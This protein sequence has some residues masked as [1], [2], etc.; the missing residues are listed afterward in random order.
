MNRFEQHFNK[1]QAH[2]RTHFNNTSNL[3]NRDIS[4]SIC[5]PIEP[6]TD[7][8]DRFWDY[9][10]Y[11]SP[12][13][14]FSRHT[15]IYFEDLLDQ[16]NNNSIQNP[17]EFSII[18]LIFSCRYSHIP[19]D[20]QLLRQNLINSLINSNYFQEELVIDY[21]FEAPTTVSP[22]QSTPDTLSETSDTDI[23]PPHLEFPFNQETPITPET[24]VTTTMDG[25]NQ[26]DL[27][28]LTQAINALLAPLQAQTQATNRNTNNLGQRETRHIEIQPFFG[29][30]QDPLTWVEDFERMA[31]ANG[32]GDNRKLQVIPAYLRGEASVWYRTAALT[33]AFGHWDDNA[34]ADSF[35]QR[36]L[37]KYR[38]SV[39][40][41]IWANELI[42]C[43]QGPTE[44]VDS[45]STRMYELY[46]RLEADGNDYP[47]AD[48]IR[49]FMG[50]LRFELQTAVR[51]FRDQD[52]DDVVNRAKS[53][54][55]GTQGTSMFA[56]TYADPIPT[57]L[58]TNTNTLMVNTL[59]TI[60]KQIEN[61]ERKIT[62]SQRNGN[63]NGNNTNNMNRNWRQNNNNNGNNNRP[64]NQNWRNNNNNQVQ[65]NNQF[66]IN[67]S[68]FNNNSNPIV[69]YNCQQP[70]H[71]SREC[72]QPKQYRNFNQQNQNFN[73][74]AFNQQNQNF[75]SN[76]PNQQT[77]NQQMH[78]SFNT[79]PP[80]RVTF[81]DTPQI[82]LS[83]QPPPK[84]PN[85]E[86]LS[87]QVAALASLME[88]LNY[89]QHQ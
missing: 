6:P 59:Q 4:C 23:L 37:A 36:F 86:Q 41:D 75:N 58:N 7:S 31:L 45:Y 26:N 57:S 88:S 81:A 65:S 32:I 84:D 11:I 66:P 44:T 20:Y 87:N 25:P 80:R 35:V 52:W 60:T 69:C 30:N 61:L 19:Q 46:R 62:A 28:N 83:N 38:T 27:R 56:N 29:G 47:A 50:G 89:P 73:S 67:N 12:A 51:P 22:L 74:N 13:T 16:V 48:K 15:Q 33:Q 2:D 68:G 9:Y 54:E 34:E 40:I 42:N 71:M 14:S 3:R 49:R 77:A 39:L 1:N 10:S 8:F 43:Q 79:P 82:P 85:V 70:G 18:G 72:P 17:H 76:V 55:L 63:N 5:Y 21:S 24:P 78:Q 53:C 64:N